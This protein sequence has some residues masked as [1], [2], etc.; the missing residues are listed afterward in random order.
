MGPEAPMPSPLSGAITNIRFRTALLYPPL[1]S[2]T[3]HLL[4]HQ[5]LAHPLARV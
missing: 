2:P 5:T 1:L 4:V 3:K